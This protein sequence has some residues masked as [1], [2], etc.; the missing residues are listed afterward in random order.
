MY[1]CILTKVKDESFQIQGASIKDADGVKNLAHI[2]RSHCDEPCVIVIC[3]EKQQ[4]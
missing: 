2:L 4:I 1:F 3:M